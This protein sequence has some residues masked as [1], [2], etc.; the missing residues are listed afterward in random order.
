VPDVQATQGGTL[1]QA[2][3]APTSASADSAVQPAAS[4]QTDDPKARL[5]R[6]RK[7]NKQSGRSSSKPILIGG[8]QA[9]SK[10][11]E[12][13]CMAKYGKT[14]DELD[15]WRE[16]AIEDCKSK[17]SAHCDDPNWIDRYAPKTLDQ[18]RDL[19]DERHDNARARYNRAQ[20]HNR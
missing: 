8:G 9:Q 10:P 2:G 17:D 18:Q 3:G 1:N 7:M 14:C 5:R 6:L 12:S 11:S 20:K 15:H 13:S 19:Q 4:Q 16:K